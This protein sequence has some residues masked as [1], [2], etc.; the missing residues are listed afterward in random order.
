MGSQRPTAL[1]TVDLGSERVKASAVIGTDPMESVS[2]LAV[3]PDT[4]D[5]PPAR[6]RFRPAS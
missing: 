4:F 3:V 1:H 6:L 2:S 5:D